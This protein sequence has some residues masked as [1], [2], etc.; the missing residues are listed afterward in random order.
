MLFG[1]YTEDVF[2]KINS[3]TGIT[4]LNNETIINEKNPS[5]LAYHNGIL[6]CVNELENGEISYYKEGEK[7]E[8][9]KTGKYPCHINIFQDKVLV[10]N[11][12]GGIILFVILENGL[13]KI[14]SLNFKHEIIN[15]QNLERQESSHPH[16][17]IYLED[18]NQ[19]VVAD[20]GNDK[21]YFLSLDKDILVIS[22]EIILKVGSGPRHMFRKNDFIYVTNE[23]SGCISKVNIQ[24]KEIT[25]YETGGNPSHIEADKNKLY[26][27]V[28]DIN[29]ILIYNIDT[30]IKTDEISLDGN[31][32]HFLIHESKIYIA[33]QDINEI[34][35]YEL[36]SKRKNKII[37]NT[38]TFILKYE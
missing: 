24:T 4:N 27:A 8:N 29:K 5:Y 15:G 37:I 26:V 34:E 18:I 11:Y 10:C 20:L 16:S 13:K 19:I 2:G 25:Y 31:P 17:S 32:R 9:K 38:P 30:M 22:K 1:S 3:G 35:I 7:I 33:S 21:L 28:R 23:L 12:G 36:K 14:T 6:Y